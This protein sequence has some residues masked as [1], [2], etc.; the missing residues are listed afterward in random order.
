MTRLK[1]PSWTT[2]WRKIKREKRRLFSASPAVHAQYDPNSYS[3]NFDDGYSN[4]PDN[5]SRSFSARF[6]VPSKIFEKNEIVCTADKLWENMVYFFQFF[7]SLNFSFPMKIMLLY[8]VL[9]ILLIFEL[10]VMEVLL[11]RCFTSFFFSD[12]LFQ[13]WARLLSIQVH[14]I[15]LSLKKYSETLLVKQKYSSFLI[16]LKFY[17]NFSNIE[18]LIWLCGWGL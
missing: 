10:D 12:L 7:S 1:I 3:Q 4:D 9:D 6:A 11:L 13:F 15:N 17:L 2:F 14:H 18:L 8:I 5:V 16:Q